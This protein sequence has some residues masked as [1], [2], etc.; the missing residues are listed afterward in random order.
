VIFSLMPAGTVTPVSTQPAVAW[1]AN[2]R[3]RVIVS[4]HGG[5]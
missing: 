3:L 5:T 2:P 4:G 1:T